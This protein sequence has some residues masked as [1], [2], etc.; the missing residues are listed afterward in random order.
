M[1][2][3]KKF[4]ILLGLLLASVALFCILFISSNNTALHILS[5]K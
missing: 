1:S 3:Q 2:E 5:G 4:W